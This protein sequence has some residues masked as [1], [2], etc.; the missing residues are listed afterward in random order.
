MLVRISRLLTTCD[1]AALKIEELL[2]NLNM[3][4][5]IKSVQCMEQRLVMEST[6]MVLYY[7]P[8][9]CTTCGYVVNS[10]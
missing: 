1:W 3:S 2:N 9:M 8:Y 7:R 5:F 4:S 6:A 10:S